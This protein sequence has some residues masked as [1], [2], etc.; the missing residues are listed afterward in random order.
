MEFFER[1]ARASWGMAMNVF[2]LLYVGEVM[3]RFKRLHFGFKL[4][5][6][7]PL[8]A[9]VARAQDFKCLGHLCNY[10]LCLKSITVKQVLEQVYLHLKEN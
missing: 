3:A 4:I 8:L 2:A 6:L 10:F 9:C 1:D 5:L 7:W